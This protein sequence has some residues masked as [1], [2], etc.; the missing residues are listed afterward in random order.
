MLDFL[1]QTLLPPYD[2]GIVFAHW[3]DHIRHLREGT[4]RRQYQT[5]RM[6]RHLKC[7]QR[8]LM[9]LDAQPLYGG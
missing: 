8:V 7:I 5:D 2:L 6:R 3:L 9:S 4:R 1:L